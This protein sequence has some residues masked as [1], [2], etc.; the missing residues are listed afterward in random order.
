MRDLI[1]KMTLLESQEFNRLSI[2]DHIKKAEFSNY[3]LKLDFTIPYQH[4]DESDEIDI[5]CEIFFLY[6]LD[7]TN[8]LVS[9]ENDV[10]FFP[11]Y[12]P[13]QHDYTTLQIEKDAK[14]TIL[15]DLK[16][17]LS[18]VGFSSDAVN[19][20]AVVLNSANDLEIRNCDRLHY[21]VNESYKWRQVTIGD[22]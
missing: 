18:K 2:S 11:R 1:N 9:T 5:I 13:R 17:Q 21:E 10:V 8:D 22:L 15:P 7:N 14:Y 4:D 19:K 20:I 16:K 6:D 12:S 3:Q